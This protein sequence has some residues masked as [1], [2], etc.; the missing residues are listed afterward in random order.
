M[1]CALETAQDEH[2][3][4][5]FG[6]ETETERNPSL[7][8]TFSVGFFHTAAARCPVCAVVLPACLVRLLCV[9]VPLVH[10]Q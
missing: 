4:P 8:G 9:R 6:K 5:A 2:K 10:S 3:A 1:P 7:T